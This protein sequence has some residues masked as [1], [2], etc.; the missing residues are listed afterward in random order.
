MIGEIRQRIADGGELPVQ[1]RE[2]ARRGGIDD[3]VVEPKVAMNDGSTGI[4]RAGGWEPIDQPVHLRHLLGFRSSVLFRPTSDLPRHIA[5][6][7]AEVAKAEC[8]GI[9]AVQP[10]DGGIERLKQG[11]TVLSAQARRIGFPEHAALGM[12]HDIEGSADDAVVRTQMKRP[13]HG[14]TRASAA[15]TR[16]SRSM[17]CAEGSSLPK[18]CAAERK[19][20]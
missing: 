9:E 3:A 18:G 8:H 4:R 5:L 15:V 10:G 7:L 17:A 13:R 12:F 19:L 20:D 6:R 2:N 1:H 14:K 11:R 16:Y